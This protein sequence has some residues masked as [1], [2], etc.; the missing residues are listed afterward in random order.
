MVGLL[1][2][3]H[4]STRTPKPQ[5]QSH[6]SPPKALVAAKNITPKTSGEISSYG[7]QSTPSQ[8]MALKSSKPH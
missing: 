8:N 1:S 4:P 3:P 6:L 5:Q 2:D 7:E